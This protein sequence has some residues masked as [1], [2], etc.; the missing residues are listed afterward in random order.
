MQ[1][2]GPHP[3]SAYPLVITDH[4]PIAGSSGCLRFQ[5]SVSLGASP[6]VCQWGAISL[7][8][9]PEATPYIIA[10]AHGS[11]P[12]P[13]AMQTLAGLIPD[14]VKAAVCSCDEVGQAHDCCYQADS[15]PEFLAYPWGDDYLLPGDYAMI[16]LPNPLATVDHYFHVYQAQRL[17]VCETAERSMSWAVKAKF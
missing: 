13:M 10:I 9:G 8:E 1:C 4:I 17:N 11:E 16:E 5:A 3:L 12:T 14:P 6:D 2:S 15:P 7:Y